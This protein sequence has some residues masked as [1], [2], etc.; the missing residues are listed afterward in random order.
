MMIRDGA[1]QL[2]PPGKV[3]SIHTHRFFDTTLPSWLEVP[4]GTFTALAPSSGAGSGHAEF[5]TGSAVGNTAILRTTMQFWGS[6]WEALKI[7]VEGLKFQHAD[8]RFDF[9]FYTTGVNANPRLVDFGLSEK[10][11]LVTREPGAVLTPVDMFLMTGNQFTRSRNLSLM[12]Y[13]KTKWVYVMEDD[14][15]FGAFYRP[16]MFTA[17]ASAAYM[18]LTNLAANTRWWRAKQVKLETW[19][20]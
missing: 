16:D 10:L 19:S 11:Q 7:S 12:F 3:H 2:V 17:G 14:Q 1:G 20:N 13:P 15:V 9:G 4:S 18:G 5:T 6:N 8:T